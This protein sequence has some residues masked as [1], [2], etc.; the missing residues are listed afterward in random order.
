MPRRQ[1]DGSDIGSLIVFMA[2]GAI[3]P[4]FVSSGVWMYLKYTRS[5]GLR[6]LQF[7]MFTSPSGLSGDAR[8]ELSTFG[9]D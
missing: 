4:E 1:K 2:E 6:N 7:E 3:S 5:T 8:T 9:G